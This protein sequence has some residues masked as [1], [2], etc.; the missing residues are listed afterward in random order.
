MVVPPIGRTCRFMKRIAK[1]KTECTPQPALTHLMG[2]IWGVGPAQTAQPRV[3]PKP[4]QISTMLTIPA[5]MRKFY[6][7]AFSSESKE[8]RP[9]LRAVGKP[10]L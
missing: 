10:L 2:G 7:V 8:R 6:S 3:K 1:E 4:T 9:Y 5:I